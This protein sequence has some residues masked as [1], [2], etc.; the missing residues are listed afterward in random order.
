MKKN[1]SMFL[2]MIMVSIIL[3]NCASVG[4]DI[5]IPDSHTSHSAAYM[6]EFMTIDQ[7]VRYSE[8]TKA[9]GYLLMTHVPVSG[10]ESARV[11]KILEVFQ[12]YYVDAS[13]VTIEVDSRYITIIVITENF[14]E[15]KMSYDTL[16]ELYDLSFSQSMISFIN[17]EE[18]NISMSG[19]GPYLVAFDRPYPHSTPDTKM[20]YLDLSNYHEDDLDAAFAAWS[21]FLSFEVSDWE[22]GYLRTRDKYITLFNRY[23]DFFIAKIGG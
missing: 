10:P 18:K 15:N 12:G 11:E 17:R 8:T 13:D 22:M 9:Q 4:R 19:K 2:L 5:V 14:T 6:R 3:A 21:L 16:L 1:S 23:A 20:V 7:L